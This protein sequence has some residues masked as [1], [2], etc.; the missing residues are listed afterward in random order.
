M[1]ACWSLT[2]KLNIRVCLGCKICAHI[3]LPPTH[4]IQQTNA[5]QVRTRSAFFN[6]VSE[7]V[8]RDPIEEEGLP[9]RRIEKESP[10]EGHPARK[11][12]CQ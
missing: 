11:T 4:H 1:H 9:P 2:Q 10:E 3:A 6:P 12:T 5:I 8:G 7:L